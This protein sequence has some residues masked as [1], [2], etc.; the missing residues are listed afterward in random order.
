MIALVTENVKIALA[1]L[2]A[3]PFRSALTTLGIVIAVSAVIA[4]VSIVQ[5]ASKFMLDQIE[6]L[7]S[8]SFW[9]RQDRP[10]GDTGRALGH[11]E[12]TIEDATAVAQRCPSVMALSPVTFTDGTIHWR[13]F[14]SDAQ[15]RGTVSSYQQTRNSWVDLGRCSRRSTSRTART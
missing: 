5:G 6:G 11:I 8:N 13:G 14:K 3:N 12:L 9:V 4:V 2:R 10:P 1:E 7:G 15:I